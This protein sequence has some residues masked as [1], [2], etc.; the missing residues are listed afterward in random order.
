MGLDIRVYTN[1]KFINSDA[2]VVDEE[3][4]FYIVD[5]DGIRYEEDDVYTIYVGDGD[6]PVNQSEG[7][8]TNEDNYV[9]LILKDSDNKYI[10]PKYSFR[11]GS[12]SGY[13][14]W[15]SQLVDLAGYKSSDADESIRAWYV[16]PFIEQID[17]SDCEGVMNTEVSKK[18]YEDY[19]AYDH[20]AQLIGGHFYEK[21]KDFKESYKIASENNGVVVF[22]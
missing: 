1:A 7:L 18:L 12:Y 6:I 5:A 10:N 22:G 15:K 4:E 17:F 16:G 3:E 21:Y 13:F 20:L 9:R 2:F 14:A 19:L 8:P 11:A